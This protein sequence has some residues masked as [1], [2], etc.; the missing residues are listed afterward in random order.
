MVSKAQPESS[1]ASAKADSNEGNRFNE[2]LKKA[3]PVV[4]VILLLL[5]LL[6]A[7]LSSF[8]FPPDGPGTYVNPAPKVIIVTGAQR[9]VTPFE[10]NVSGMVKGGSPL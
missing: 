9:S 6:G 8:F 2:R 7:L 3:L 1:I 4:V 10:F 5:G